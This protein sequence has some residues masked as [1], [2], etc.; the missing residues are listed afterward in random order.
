MFLK[1]YIF[2]I[3]LSAVGAILTAACGSEANEFRGTIVAPQQQTT[4]PTT[5]QQGIPTTS[6]TQ[7]TA[8]EAPARP[9][10]AT[11]TPRPATPTTQPATATA[12]PPTATP[13][14]ATPTPPPATSEPAAPTT[15]PTAYLGEE[16]Q[17]GSLG[18]VWTLSD[19]RVGTHPGK[20]RVV[21]EMAE[22]R[23]AAPLTKIV[24]VDNSETP[25]PQR[26]SLLDP[27]W[28]K[29]RIDIMMSDCYAYGIPLNEELP[30]ALPEGLLVTKVGLHPTFDDALLGFSIGLSRPAPYE[31]YTL[32]EPVR[33]VVDV[34]AH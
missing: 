22:S 6:P 17:V 4:S 25:F 27:S 9:Q 12:T 2:V 10:A 24:E 33:I 5:S 19:I 7:P 18:N 32:A 31:V 28:G 1:R 20:I 3:L 34:I 23:N 8:P 16:R 29:A 30:I 13:R 14:L 21:W 26:G 15:D 11:P